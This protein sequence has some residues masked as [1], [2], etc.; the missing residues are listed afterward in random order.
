VT[1]TEV[2]LP[3]RE[4]GVLLGPRLVRAGGDDAGVV[5][6]TSR[7]REVLEVTARHARPITQ[8][9]CR[10]LVRVE[11]GPLNAKGDRKTIPIRAI[12]VATDRTASAREPLILEEAHTVLVIAVKIAIARTPHEAERP[13]IERVRRVVVVRRRVVVI[14]RRVVVIRR[15]VVV[16]VVV[17]RGNVDRVLVVATGVG[18]TGSQDETDEEQ[19][20]ETQIHCGRSYS[21]RF[22]L[23]QGGFLC[24]GERERRRRALVHASA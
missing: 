22:S 1:R 24:P 4:A 8:V 12:E 7:L 21:G 15:R 9:F 14:R 10:G 6:A 2:R 16:V 13:V 19:R 20:Q 11:L 17:Q 18:R 3:V 5:R 23:E